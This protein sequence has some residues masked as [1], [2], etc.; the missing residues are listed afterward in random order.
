MYIDMHVHMLHMHLYNGGVL[1]LHAYKSVYICMYTLMYIYIYIFIYLFILIYLCILDDC[2][3][4]SEVRRAG[5]RL[6]PATGNRS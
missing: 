4:G 1:F 3:Y 5:L 6:S 2:I